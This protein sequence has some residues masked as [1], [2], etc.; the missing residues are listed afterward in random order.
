MGDVLRDFCRSMG[1]K[2]GHPSEIKAG[3]LA[4]EFA[5]HFLLSSQPSLVEFH[6]LAD[7]LGIQVEARSLPADLGAH[8]YFN[9]SAGKY[10]VEYQYEQWPGTSEFK[11][12][13]EFYEI[14]QETFEEE[15]P[16]YCA[17]R[18]PSHPTCMAPH[19]N[20]FAAALLMNAKLVKR[21]AMESGL[22]MIAMHRRFFKSYAAVAIRTVEVLGKDDSAEAT[23]LLIAIYERDA[24]GDA[25]SSGSA[26]EEFRAKYVLRTPGIKIA[27]SK[28][29]RAL[30]SYPRDLFPHKGDVILE[31]SIVDVVRQTC[32]DAYLERVRGFDLWGWND[33]TV[34][35]RP[36]FWFGDLAKI[37]LIAVRHE[38]RHLL[39]PQLAALRPVVIPESY[40]RI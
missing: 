33:L 35:V 31:Q 25:S 7:K 9:R 5:E 1:C 23:D 10:W 8:H 15:T 40:Q 27:R 34:V 22:D 26:R 30:L 3:I 16:Y 38:H 39:Q 32:R 19:A 2:Y 12:A 6:L 37:L 18:H 4:A 36:V 24:S 28:R 14:L 20:R 21:L 11:L 17:P 29:R 13:H